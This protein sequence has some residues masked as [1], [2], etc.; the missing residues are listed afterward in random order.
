MRTANEVTDQQAPHYQTADK[1]GQ[2]W[3]RAWGLYR[4][5][6][7][8][9]NITKYVERHSKKNGMADLRKAQHYLQKL[10]ELE[11]QEAVDNDHKIQ[12]EETPLTRMIWLAMNKCHMSLLTEFICYTIERYRKSC[13]TNWTNLY[14]CRRALDNL[15]NL[16][17]DTEKT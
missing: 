8:V 16:V 9:L 10:I 6:W 5:A 14:N 7:F 2:H 13:M 11:S 3:D 12:T 4:E 17:G 15:V 1:Q